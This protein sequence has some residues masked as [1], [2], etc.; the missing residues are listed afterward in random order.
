MHS[1]TI[2]NPTPSKDQRKRRVVKRAYSFFKRKSVRNGRG[3][4]NQHGAKDAK[5]MPDD[6]GEAQQ[7]VFWPYD[8]L[9]AVCKEA[10]ILTWGYDTQIT[11]YYREPTTKTNLFVLGKSLLWEL[12][13]NRARDRPVVFVAHSLGGIVIKQA[14]NEEQRYPDGYFLFHLL[15]KNVKENDGCLLDPVST[16]QCG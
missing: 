8:L 13:R 4:K 12:A 5:T 10:R 7:L 2:P 6:L 9:P 14:S 16:L 15:L 11:K 3:A 1:D